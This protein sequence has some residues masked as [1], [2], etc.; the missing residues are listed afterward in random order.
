MADIV[1]ILIK[2]G[3]KLFT[4]LVFQIP[5]FVVMLLLWINP[6]WLKL[7]QNWILKIQEVAPLIVIFICTV[8]IV[9]IFIW[10]GKKL[11]FRENVRQKVRGIVSNNHIYS[12]YL[13]NNFL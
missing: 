3:K 7:K 10:I 2:H 1:D 4:S 5:F 13:E 6:G 11:K 12:S 9:E 8:W